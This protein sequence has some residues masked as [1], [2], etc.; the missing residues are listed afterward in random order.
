MH[1]LVDGHECVLAAL[2]QSILGV[3]YTNFINKRSKTQVLCFWTLS[4]IL[5][6]F[7][8]NISETGFC[9]HLQVKPTQLGP[10]DRASPCLCQI[11]S[12]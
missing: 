3:G 4:I 9:P 5:F 6:L 10:F 11:V 7:K 8:S 2:I 1:A 12:Q